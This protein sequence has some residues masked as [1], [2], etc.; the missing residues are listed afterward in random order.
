MTTSAGSRLA[1]PSFLVD[2]IQ[3]RRLIAQWM[4]EAHQGHLGNVGTVTLS[5][6]VAATTVTDF[7]VGPN[8]FIGLMPTTANAAAEVGGG[9]VYISSRSAEGFT[10]AH[11]NTATAD[12]AFVYCV[13]G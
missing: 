12:R 1:P 3:H 5:T 9:T 4:R 6:S 13:L 11:A 7:R 2:E 8:S 10:I